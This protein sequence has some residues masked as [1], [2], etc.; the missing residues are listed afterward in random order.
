[1]DQEPLG[2]SPELRTPR[3]LAAHVGA[4]TD[5]LE[6]GSEINAYDISRTSNLADLLDACDLASHSWKQKLA[7]EGLEVPH[8]RQCRE[9]CAL[10]GSARR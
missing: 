7:S 8:D 9:P 6:H 10:I 3:L 1:M 4:G 5:H 2:L